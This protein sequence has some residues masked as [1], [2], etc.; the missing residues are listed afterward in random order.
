MS[1]APRVLVALALLSLLYAAAYSLTPYVI[2]PS[3]SPCLNLRP[4]PSTGAGP[5]D[6]VAPGTLSESD[7]PGDRPS[8]RD[9][10]AS[11]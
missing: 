2:K 10:A 4:Q 8:E 9:G 1:S 6:C 3:A 7:D 11:G 5:T